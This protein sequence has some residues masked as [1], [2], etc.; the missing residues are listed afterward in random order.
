MS[1]YLYAELRDKLFTDEG[2]RLF[3][4]VRDR[5]QA[6]LA[7]SG[8]AMVGAIIRGLSG[9]SWEMLACVDRLVELGELRE[10]VQRD[11]AGLH[12]VF[13]GTGRVP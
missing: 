11:V 7:E 8:A 9:D 6:L 2:Q 5:A 4:K 10:V 12:R 13:V 3:L 1:G